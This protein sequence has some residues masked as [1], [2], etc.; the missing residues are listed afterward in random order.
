MPIRAIFAAF[1]CIVIVVA[2]SHALHAG[3]SDA[4]SDRRVLV[5]AIPR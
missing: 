4:K 3:K 1:E 2:A 5:S